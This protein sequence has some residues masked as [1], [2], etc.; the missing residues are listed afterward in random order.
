M[1]WFLYDNGL[2]LERVN[3]SLSA[4]MFSTC[5]YLVLIFSVLLSTH[6]VIY[7]ENVLSIWANFNKCLK[8]FMASFSPSSSCENMCQGQGWNLTAKTRGPKIKSHM[9]MFI[10]TNDSIMF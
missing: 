10:S 4:H 6:S 7:S 1:D 5:I 8:S 2:R 3:Q 9:T